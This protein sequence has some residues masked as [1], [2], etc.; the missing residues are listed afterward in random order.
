MTPELDKDSGWCQLSSHTLCEIFSVSRR[1]RHTCTLRKHT[2]LHAAHTD[3]LCAVELIPFYGTQ[4]PHWCKLGMNRWFWGYFC[5]K[6]MQVRS[7]PS[8]G[9]KEILQLMNDPSSLSWACVRAHAHKHVHVDT[10]W[11]CT[12]QYQVWIWN[13]NCVQLGTGNSAPARQRQ[14]EKGQKEM[15]VDGYLWNLGK[16]KA[17]GA[18]K[19]KGPSLRLHW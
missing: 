15:E 19:E 18:F 10:D 6:H 13:I 5:L 2:C 8:N 16:G 4:K 14:R 9:N 11:L 12:S 17:G 7:P 3:Q 1:Q